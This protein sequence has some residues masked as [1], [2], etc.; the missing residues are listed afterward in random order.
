MSGRRKYPGAPPAGAATGPSGTTPPIGDFNPPPNGPAQPAYTPDMY[1]PQQGNPQQMY[2]VQQEFASMSIN[3]ADPQQQSRGNAQRMAAPPTDQGAW[4]QHAPQE[5]VSL[6]A[7]VPE[8]ANLSCPPEYLRLTMGC[9]PQSQELL[10]ASQIP[11]GAIIHPL[12]ETSDTPVRANLSLKTCLQHEP[13]SS[14]VQ[15][16]FSILH[17]WLLTHLPT[18]LMHRS[19]S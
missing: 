4:A 9:V 6:A 12:A 8:Q 2:P 13:S 1:A 19:L 14:L 3:G 15:S 11:F 17:V 5:A 10:N 18:I 7:Y 16:L